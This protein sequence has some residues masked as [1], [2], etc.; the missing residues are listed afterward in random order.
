MIKHTQKY[1]IDQHHMKH[2]ISYIKKHL[3]IFYKDIKYIVDFFSHHI[4]HILLHKVF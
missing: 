2:Y 4:V 1:Y 3:N